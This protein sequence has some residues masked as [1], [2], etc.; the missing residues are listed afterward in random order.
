MSFVIGFVVVLGVLIFFHELGHFIV[1]K[2]FGVGV[3][4]FSLGFGPKILAKTVGRTEYRLS[5]IPLGGYVKMVGEQPDEELDPADIPF[6]FT[7]KPVFQRI[8]IVASGPVFNFLLAIIIFFGIFW[9]AGLMM[10]QPVIGEVKAGF[11]AESA[12][13]ISGDKIL[14]I[15]DTP[16]DNWSEMAEMIMDSNGSPLDF[17]MLR[18]SQHINLSVTPADDVVENIFGEEQHRYIIGVSST[19][20]VITRRLGPVE[21]FAESLNRTYLICKLTILSVVKIFQG[22][23][24]AKTI[25][26]PI[27]IA[28]MAGEQV[29]QGAFNLLAFIALI[30]VN[31]GILNLLP[32]P[33]LDGGHILFFSI[34][35]VIRR[36][37]SIKTREIAQQVG[38][39]LLMMLMVF[40]FY[41]DIMRFFEK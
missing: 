21:A 4:K 9:F 19:G 8:L 29:E 35:A 17:T 31:L 26:G 34:E 22:A 11:P 12:G 38:I 27:L 33:V 18:D 7:H 32:I 15:N 25:G 39:F 6:S 1:A 10:L 13:I 30:S 2:A 14:A 5:A 37:V 41:N 16:I 36:P 23:I 28:Q 24:P 20:D 40:V 3:E